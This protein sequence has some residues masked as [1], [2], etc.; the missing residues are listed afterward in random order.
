MWH[1][2]S[3]RGRCDSGGGRGGSGGGPS[4]RGVLGKAG[5]GGWSRGGLEERR[6][7]PPTAAPLHG[8]VGRAASEREAGPMVARAGR[9]RG[10]PA[11]VADEPVM[12]PGAW[13]PFVSG[14]PFK[15]P[16]PQPGCGASGDKGR[17]RRGP[18][19]TPPFRRAF[20]VLGPAGGSARS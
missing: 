18:S 19:G 12:K 14:K 16:L 9:A 4:K 20:P 15:K 6:P 3:S 5:E 11:G 2:R 17:R 13:A 7:P 10:G 1:A 8:S